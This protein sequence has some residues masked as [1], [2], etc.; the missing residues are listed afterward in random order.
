[1][2]LAVRLFALSL[3]AAPALAAGPLLQK[4]Q[5]LDKNHDGKLTADELPDKEWFQRLDLNHDGE[6][7]LAEA[8][9][10]LIAFRGG[11]PGVNAAQAPAAAAPAP[12]QEAPKIL[13]P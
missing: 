1:M 8:I 7:P 5:E 12:V 6:V 11:I 13:K 10:A 9:Q 2:K 4:F 3:V